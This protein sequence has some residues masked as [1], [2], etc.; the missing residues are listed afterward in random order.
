MA[1]SSTIP[2]CPL[3]SAG[4]D[5]NSVCAQEN[6]A[7]YIQNLKTCAIYVMAHNALLDVKA[8]QGAKS[9]E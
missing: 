4:K 1:N 2:I 9:A 6:C 5:V 7:W 3:I 8:K